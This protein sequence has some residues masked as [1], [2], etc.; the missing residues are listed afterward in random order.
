[1]LLRKIGIALI[2]LAGVAMVASFAGRKM[3]ESSP[4]YGA[5][6]FEID[7]KFGNSSAKLTIPI[8]RAFNFSEGASSG[9]ANFV[10]CSEKRLCYQVNAEKN[11][12]QWAVIARNES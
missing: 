5:A 10:L 3:I 2:V 11:N 7:T 12:G 9:R 8:F 6:I 4:V 1:M